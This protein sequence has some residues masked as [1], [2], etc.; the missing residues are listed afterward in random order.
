M[1]SALTI[2]TVTGL[3]LNYALATLSLLAIAYSIYGG[4]KAI[5]LTD[6]V[7]VAMLVLGG[8]LIAYLVL[9]E[10]GAGEGVIAEFTTP[11]DR[12]PEKFDMILSPDN[13]NYIYLPGLSVLL[14]G[15]WIMNLPY[16]GFNQY[17]IQRA[18]AAK[19]I[20]EA[21]R[22][23]AFAAYLKLLMPV[24]VVLPGIAAVLLAPD[25][26]AAD[27]AYP[28]MMKLAPDGI[29]G[30]IFAALIAAILSSL[31]S[32]MNSIST[33]FTVDP[34]SRF[35]KQRSE[36]ELLNIGR[37]VAVASIAVAAVIAQPLPGRFD[38]A[39][40]YIQEF[41]GF[42]TPGIVTIFL[43]G[44]FFQRITALAA[45]AIGPAVF[46]FTLYIAWPG[47][48]FMDRFGVVFLLCVATAISVSAVSRSPLSD[49]ARRA[50][51]GADVDYSTT[52]GFNIASIGVLAILVALYL[53][54]W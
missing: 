14:G 43:L 32:M 54:W 49:Q 5:A 11:V 39:F 2:N 3:E 46:S 16:R 36:R 21:Q 40:Q 38:Q 51:T 37:V 28:E 7:Q 29:R 15:M 33:I 27:Q 50:T 47:L 4:L 34:Y 30:I 24:I 41:T 23:I 12:V 9:V 8:L 26:R 44:M 6:I 13:P 25:I 22:G 31:G 52:A 48:S 35:S 42:F 18:L 1:A 10:I 19:S 45:L 53:T 17:L 20:Q